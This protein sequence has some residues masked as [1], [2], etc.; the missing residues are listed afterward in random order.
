[1]ARNRLFVV[2]ACLLAVLG[3]QVFG[4]GFGLFENSARGV[5]LGGALVGRADD[6]SALYYNP[7]GITQL[8]GLHW[9]VGVSGISPLTT[10]VDT[11]TGESWDAETGVWTPPH[12][13]I[14][15]QL[16][17]R[18]VIGAAVF[19]P[20]G[21]AVEFDENW[22]GRYNSYFAEVQSLAINPNIAFKVTDSFSLAVGF[23]AQWL[24]VEMKQ[25]ISPAM[26]VMG[27]AQAIIQG[28]M[29]QGVDQ[30]TA[31]LIFNTQALPLAASLGDMDQQV[32]GDSTEYGFNAALRY[33][34]SKKFALG[35]S[36]RAA[37]DQD[38]DGDAVY[39]GVPT[40]Y[41]FLPFQGIF[42]DAGGATT[43]NLP[44]LL[45][46]GIAHQ[47]NDKISIEGDAWRSGWSS[48]EALTLNFENGLGERVSEKNWSDTWCY[49]AGLE[50]ARDDTWTYRFGWIYDNTPIPDN[51]VDYQLPAND[52]E[53]VCFG[54]GFKGAKYNFDA[55]YMYGNIESRHITAQPADGIFE[56]ETKD[57]AAHLYGLT[58]SF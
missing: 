8:E 10:V 32:A 25:K 12:L 48:Y 50:Y 41:P 49:R 44:D 27:N 53:Y 30:A 23:S 35:I 39:E 11:Q 47:A 7:A 4:S 43:M 5:A 54:V 37:I 33:S 56:S 45:Q 21:L 14:S 6:V 51:D 13:F 22:Q 1:M 28:I 2:L 38:I 55:Y 42:F 15:K 20:F 36:Y 40:D 26:V 9:G 3:S 17:D 29:A 31:E 34:P 57:G 58:F 52:R 16:G 24:D 46:I 19:S 18:I